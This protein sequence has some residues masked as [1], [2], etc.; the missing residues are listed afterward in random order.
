MLYNFNDTP[1]SNR[2]DPAV[3]NTP[4]AVHNPDSPDIAQ[5]A[6][7]AEEIINVSGADVEVYM[8]TDNKDYD[9]VWDADADPTYW[10]KI[11]LKGFFIPKPS[12]TVLTK[13]GSDTPIKQEIVFSKAVVMAETRDRSL[14]VGDVIKVPYNTK[15]KSDTYRITN[16]QETGNFRYIWLYINCQVETI[17]GDITVAVDKDN[18]KGDQQWP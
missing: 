7:M 15:L 13:W 14:R 12:E 5:A 4:I 1:I 16:V 3:Q 11:P 10:S 6:K 2:M 8:R 18:Y 9:A 17:T